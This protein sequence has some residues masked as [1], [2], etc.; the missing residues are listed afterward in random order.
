MFGINHRLIVSNNGVCVL[1]KDD[2]R[3][4]RMR[5]ASL[6]SLFVVLAKIA[7]RMKKLLRDDGRFELDVVQR[8]EERLSAR[9][10]DAHSVRRETGH[11]AE[12]FMCSV[13]AGVS[14]AEQRPHVRWNQ[15]IG[16]A[17]EN[18]FAL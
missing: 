1:K 6:R 17:V 9:A 8:V 11:V 16:H 12:S 2:P 18:R 4:H 5:K 13:K 3:H 15:S 14:A 10:S 7:R